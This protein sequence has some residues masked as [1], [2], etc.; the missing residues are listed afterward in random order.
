MIHTRPLLALLGASMAFATT[1]QAQSLR[2]FDSLY[3]FGDSLSDSG[4]LYAASGRAEP[5]SPPYYQ[6]RFSNGQVWTEMLGHPLQLASV[7]GPSVRKD[8]N[9]AF[10]GAIS[11]RSAHN[12]VSLPV[13]G[14]PELDTQIDM[15]QARGLV[16]GANDLFTVWAGANNILGALVYLPTFAPFYAEKAAQDACIGVDR[17]AKLGARTIVVMNMPGLGSTPRFVN[18]GLTAEYVNRCSDAYN[19][20]LDKDLAT[21]V[22]SYSTDTNIVRIDIRK[23]LDRVIKDHKILGFDNASQA[24]LSVSGT[25]ATVAAGVHVFWDSIHPT[26]ETHRIIADI[27]TESVNP[28]LPLGQSAMVADA[29]RALSASF[30]Q[31]VSLREADLMDEGIRQQPLV[32]TDF[33][34]GTTRGRGYSLTPETRHRTVATTAGGDWHLGNDFRAGVVLGAGKQETSSDAGDE[35]SITGRSAQC[36]GLWQAQNLLL[37]ARLGHTWGEANHLRRVTRFGG[38]KT[39]ADTD[40]R[41]TNAGVSVAYALK[42]GALTPFAEINYHAVSI[43]GYTE[44]GVEA[45]SFAHDDQRSRSFNATLGLRATKKAKL[46]G[47]PLLLRGTLAYNTDIGRSSHHVSGALADNFT[48]TTM[49]NV[50]GPTDKEFNLRLLSRLDLGRGWNVAAHALLGANTWG[51]TDWNIGVNLGKRF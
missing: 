27:V 3:C 47:R 16:P 5:L 10:A 17:L 4:N 51:T 7:T 18:T 36:F 33:S 21:Q 25:Q 2:S 23:V 29:T 14:I 39:D 13:N 31:A 43:D 22:A 34:H 20:M 38:L 24:K 26:T 49:L 50:T 28:E 12:S 45:L 40:T 15:Y 46:L 48:R 41:D 30:T 44:T 37:G 42:E 8:L 32:F 1:A 11:S 19:T 6:G 9:F 35:L